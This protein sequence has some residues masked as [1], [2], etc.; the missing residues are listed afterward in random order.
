MTVLNAVLEKGGCKDLKT[1]DLTGPKSYYA[2]EH[3]A[4]LMRALSQGGL[5]KLEELNISHHELDHAV[6]DLMGA[7]GQGAC[8]GLRRLNLSSSNF[9]LEAQTGHAIALALESTYLRGLQEFQLV[10]D[11]KDFCGFHPP[12]VRALQQGCCPDL[13]VLALSGYA[14]AGTQTLGEAL[15]SGK[16]PKLEELDLFAFEGS[17]VSILEALE[18]GGCPNLKVLN[19]TECSVDDTALAYA[20]SS[21]NCR[22]LQHFEVSVDDTGMNV[23]TAIKEGA[24]PDI[25]DLAF[26]MDEECGRTFGEAIQAGACHKLRVLRLKGRGLLHVFKALES[27]GCPAMQV[28]ELQ[29]GWEE[30]GLA[31]ALV[32]TLASGSLSQLQYLGIRGSTSF[33]DQATAQ[34]ITALAAS[35]RELRRFDG[36]SMGDQSGQALL[37]SLQHRALPYLNFLYLVSAPYITD[38]LAEVLEGGFG[39]RL[40]HL[41]IEEGSMSEEGAKRLVEA[42]RGGACPLLKV[43]DVDRSLSADW[44]EDYDEEDEE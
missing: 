19:L 4:C 22:H 20:L 12:I 11:V 33:D 32:S 25:I 3:V 34:V 39:R 21:G 2:D 31:Q 37:Q 27:G 23:M 17:L 13:R 28:L 9:G 26:K 44:P 5:T 18:A 35:C 1:L 6:G 38:G 7:L 42:L 8:P 15:R 41:C 14:A 36:A 43:L 30:A 10:Y 29:Y 40:K 24:G 16:C